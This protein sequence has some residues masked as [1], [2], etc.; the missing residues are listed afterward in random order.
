MGDEPV[1]HGYEIEYWSTEPDGTGDTYHGGNPAT[2]PPHDLILFAQWI[3]LPTF[4]VTYHGNGNTGG[5]PPVDT[6]NYYPLA[7]VMLL[8]QGSMTRDGYNFAGWSTESNY[9]GPTYSAGT[10]LTMPRDPLALYAIWQMLDPPSP[11]NRV[12]NGDMSSSG[13]ISTWWND[14]RGTASYD[15]SIYS[16]GNQSLRLEQDGSHSGNDPIRLSRDADFAELALVPGK[17]YTFKASLRIS[18]D[19]ITY[20]NPGWLDWDDYA[21]IVVLLDDGNI[22]AVEGIQ[23]SDTWITVEVD[24]IAPDKPEGWISI[25]SRYESTWIDDVVLIEKE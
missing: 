22:H 6:T 17:T 15:T 5:E 3:P 1:R 23:Q 2:M 13:P 11:Y 25:E 7:S 24:F 19:Q 21:V 10:S 12:W 20:P 14:L 18:G 4:N 9:N 8:G 16:S